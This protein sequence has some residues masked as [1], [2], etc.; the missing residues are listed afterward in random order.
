[1]IIVDVSFALSGDKVPVDH[2]YL[3]YS[4]LCHRIPGLHSSDRIS[5]HPIRG[6]PVGGRL[7]Q[8]TRSSRLVFRLIEGTIDLASLVGS[9]LEIGGHPLKV[10]TARPIT[11]RPAARLFSRLVVIK[12]GKDEST[13]LQSANR[14][15]ADLGIRAGAA[16]VRKIS[17]QSREGKS[18]GNGSP[19]IRRTLRIKDKEIVG[20]AVMVEGLTADESIRLQENGLGGRGHFGCGVFVPA[21]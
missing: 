5:I 3:L 6:T 18:S 16:L 10:G 4:A 7:L 14:Q 12:G 20:F 13:F 15:L 17:P 2:A 11:L 21:R 8:L 19:F 1:M 9:S